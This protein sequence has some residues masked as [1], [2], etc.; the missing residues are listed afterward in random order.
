MANVDRPN[1]AFPVGTM[2]GNPWADSVRAYT[3]DAGHTAIAIGD[4]V[5]MAADGYLN[6]FAAGD[7]QFLG[8]CVG[9]L[10]APV[11]KVNG[12]TGNFMS[13]TQPTLV[14]ASSMQSAANTADTILVTTAKDII[15]EMQEDS[16][17]SGGTDQNAS[18]YL[19]IAATNLNIEIINATPNSTTGLSTMELDSSTAATTATLPLRLLGLVDRPDN[20][21]GAN[22]RWLV[23]P[24]NH[25]IS[26]QSVG[27]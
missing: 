15:F 17:G 3:L 8:V 9:K 6:V 19:N 24:A 13:T 20:A 27:I 16:V 12:I 4:L 5:T 14:G 26:G 22:A 1:G 7:A 25:A 2:S 23:T 18:G 21:L 11:G 10:P